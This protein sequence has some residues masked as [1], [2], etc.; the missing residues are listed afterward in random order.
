MVATE[1][2]LSHMLDLKPQ[3]LHISCHGIQKSIGTKLN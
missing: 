1:N 3:I 2:N